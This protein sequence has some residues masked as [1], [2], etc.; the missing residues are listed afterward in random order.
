MDNDMKKAIS[1]FNALC[2]YLKKNDLSF[3]ADEETLSVSLG[4]Y[5]NDISVDFIIN[6]DAQRQIFYVNSTLPFK[7]SKGNIKDGAVA[8]SCV[9]ESL[10][11]GSFDFDVDTGSIRFRMVN[12]FK[13]S[14]ISEDVFDYALHVSLNTIDEFNDKF[15]LLEEG[16]LSVNDFFD[17][18]H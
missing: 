16:K 18:L 6:V 5:T 1:V 17:L 15:L 14:L 7:M 12:C 13:E 8:T 2:S 4:F 9:N 3:D 10:L 11:A